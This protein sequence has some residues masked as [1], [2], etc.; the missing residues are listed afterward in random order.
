[1]HLCVFTWGR[2]SSPR[3]SANS[4]IRE[5]LPSNVSRTTI[6]SGVSTRWTRPARASVNC[7]TDRVLAVCGYACQ[8]VAVAMSAHTIWISTGLLRGSAATPIAVRA[9]RPWSPSTVVRSWPHPQPWTGRRTPPCWRRTPASGPRE[10]CR[11][12]RPTA[13]VATANALIAA[14]HASSLACSTLTSR[15]S[16]RPTARTQPEPVSG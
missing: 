10:P 14:R 2:R 9:W 7:F 15:P 12:H 13:M 1:M 6:G 8:P 4:C 5:T 3:A 16:T 11:G